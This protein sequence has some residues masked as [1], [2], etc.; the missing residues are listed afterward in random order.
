MN[1]LIF[2]T[3]LESVRKHRDIKLVTTEMRRKRNEKDKRKDKIN[4]YDKQNY[5]IWIQIVSLS[6]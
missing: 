2:E 1:H 4:I 5:V 3:T 6:I